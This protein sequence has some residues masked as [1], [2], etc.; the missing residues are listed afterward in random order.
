MRQG[1]ERNCR[2]AVKSGT[3]GRNP[4]VPNFVGFH[5]RNVLKL[6]S[7]CLC[8]FSVFCKSRKSPWF[9]IMSKKYSNSRL[10]DAPVVQWI[11]LHSSKGTI[12]VRILAGAPN[13]L[14]LKYLHIS[15][16]YLS[17]VY[18]FTVNKYMWTKY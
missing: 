4:T 11:E 5:S 16:I 3:R 12:Q 10:L 17:L 8:S 15:R 9:F 1:S 6:T 14:E 18:M 2:N 7:P 13:S